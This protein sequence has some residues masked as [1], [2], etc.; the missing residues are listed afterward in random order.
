MTE[1][2]SYRGTG[3]RKES[4]AQVILTKGT[5]KININRRDFDKYFTT[6]FERYNALR[7]LYQF[8]LANKYDVTAVVNGGGK[9]GQA[10]AMSLGIA[11][12]LKLADPAI[13][14]KLRGEGLLTRDPR[15][16]ERKKYGL[17]GARRGVQFSK[18]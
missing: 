1:V 12:A 18:R 16:K 2:Q 9:S 5:G 17:H 6:E 13:E 15:M 3:R 4:I 8:E 14:P 7:P 11:R 10:G